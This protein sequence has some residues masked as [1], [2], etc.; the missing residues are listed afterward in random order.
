MLKHIC[1]YK[2]ATEW[3]NNTTWGGG[4]VQPHVQL[5]SDTNEID[6]N[7]II[8][9]DESNKPLMD[10]AREHGLTIKKLEDAPY[11][12]KADAA[13]VANNQMTAFP[14]QT[15]LTEFTEF[16]FFTKVTQGTFNPRKG[17]MGCTNLKFMSF[18]P[19]FTGN[20]GVNAHIFVDVNSLEYFVGNVKGITIAGRGFNKSKLSHL[21]SE[22][23]ACCETKGSKISSSQ[24]IRGTFDTVIFNNDTETIPNE[25]WRGETHIKRI[26]CN[27]EQTPPLTGIRPDLAFQKILNIPCYVPKDC[28]ITSWTTN[29]NT[30]TRTWTYIECDRDKFGN[31]V[32]PFRLKK[33][34]E[35][36]V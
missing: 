19:S 23:A 13:N 15:G 25:G 5:R 7:Q 26:I 32:L 16:R 36:D 29:G 22:Y 9:D 12:T 27:N 28:D 18:P 24:G 8:A 2:N 17:F 1:I 34:W 30:A 20:T 11:L 35:P 21:N 14:Y 6:F 4:Y 31:L 10:I 33:W 3:A